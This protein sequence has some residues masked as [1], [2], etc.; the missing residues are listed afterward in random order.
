M[1]KII[2][3]AALLVGC[4]S[5]AQ[6]STGFIPVSDGYTVSININDTDV[7]ISMVGDENRWMGLGFGVSSMTSG[8]DVVTF[9]STGFNDRAFLG[10]GVPP[11]TD[12]QDWTLLSNTVSSG[13]RTVVAGRSL[14]GSDPTDFTFDPAADTLDIVW[15][16][17][18]STNFQNHGSGNRGIT[19]LTFSLGLNGVETQTVSLFPVPANDVLTVSLQ[20]VVFDNA[21]IEIYSALGTLVLEQAIDHKSSMI[22]VSSLAKGVYVVNVN[23]K[24][25][26]ITTRFIKE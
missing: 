10:I 11:E 2:L 26:N 17:G 1:R 24:S 5:Q 22:D 15:A 8:G 9:D 18:V 20:N 13:V 7:L 6:I 19:T 12:T 21:T 4:F 25:G 3:L 14:A 23:A 16:N